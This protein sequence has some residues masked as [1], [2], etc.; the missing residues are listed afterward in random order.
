MFLEL[1][2]DRVARLLVEDVPCSFAKLRRDGSLGSHRV[3]IAVS[4]ENDLLF[5]GSECGHTVSEADLEGYLYMAKEK[6]NMCVCHTAVEEAWFAALGQQEQNLRAV[7]DNLRALIFDIR[8]RVSVKRGKRELLVIPDKY[9]NRNKQLTRIVREVT[10]LP[11]IKVLSGNDG[12]LI[13]A[14]R[15]E[16][17]ARRA[18]DGAWEFP[19]SKR[20]S[21]R[22]LAHRSDHPQ[23]SGN[24]YC[25]ICERFFTK[26]GKHWDSEGHYKEAERKLDLALKV[27]TRRAL[28]Y[29]NKNGLS[30]LISDK[31]FPLLDTEA[32]NYKPWRLNGNEWGG[33]RIFNWLAKS[34]FPRLYN[35]GFQGLAI[36]KLAKKLSIPHWVAKKLLDDL[37]EKTL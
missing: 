10:N 2:S 33:T 24:D 9:R 4:E 31:P 13:L 8:N 23:T 12:R 30:S 16:V 28:K 20:S 35:M 34:S 7:P 37:N 15:R 32:P 3:Y 29:I 26:S 22:A 21:F 19:A 36:E 14:Q 1:N 18:I 27:T 11:Y 6:G 5:A 25:A 17:L